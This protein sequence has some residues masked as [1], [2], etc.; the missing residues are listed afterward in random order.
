M[1]R[2][3]TSLAACALAATIGLFAQEPN[4]RPSQQQQAAPET[5]TLTGCVQEAKTTA[6]GTAYVLNK[7]VGGTAP[8]YVLTG[9]PPS[10]LA[11]HVNH[12]VEVT[13]QVQ[14]PAPP[15]SE[16]EGAPKDPKV[17]RP[18]SIQIDSVKMVAD[19]CK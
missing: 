7:V 11:S 3:F 13:G 12:K 5:A 1:L 4:P 2:Y 19:N 16:A 14:Q 15:A 9:P 18:P 10:E 17:V 8:M 6:G